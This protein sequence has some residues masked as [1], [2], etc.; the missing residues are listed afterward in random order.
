[1]LRSTEVHPEFFWFV[2]FPDGCGVG[3]IM[4]LSKTQISP[5]G[6]SID[7]RKRKIE[8]ERERERPTQPGRGPTAIL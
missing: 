8:R 4:L 6:G 5:P 7:R 1:V 2:D 3:V